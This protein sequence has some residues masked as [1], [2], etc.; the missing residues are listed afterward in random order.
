VLFTKKY[1]L[2]RIAVASYANGAVVVLGL[3]AQP[4]V[5]ATYAM[6]EQLYRAMQSALAPIATAAY[7]YMS[8]ERDRSLMLKIILGTVGLTVF[9]AAIGYFTAPTLI[10]AVFGGDWVESLPVFNVFLVAIIVHS[11]A[12]MMGYPLAAAVNRANVANSS[13]ITG[14]VVYFAIFAYVL[15]FGTVTP[16]SMAGIMVMSEFCVFLHRFVVL[17]PLAIKRA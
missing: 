12:V 7:P 10:V 15:N 16:I 11:A 3:V 2:S 17:M 9:G 8:K 4:L 1:F 5:V 13:V 14:A 6:A